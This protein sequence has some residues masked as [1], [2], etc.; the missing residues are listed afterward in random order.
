MKAF[1]FRGQAI[2][3]L[4][5]KTHPLVY[6]IWVREIFFIVLHYKYPKKLYYQKLGTDSCFAKLRAISNLFS[7][8][9]TP[10]IFIWSS[11]HSARWLSILSFRTSAC[12]CNA[13]KTFCKSIH[14]KG[15][16]KPCLHCICIVLVQYCT[17]L[18][19]FKFQIVNLITYFTSLRLRWFFFV[20]LNLFPRVC[21]RL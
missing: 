11:L 15:L 6:K 3:S 8:F 20:L 18:G 2:F 4:L 16:Y 14:R 13:D 17:L 21:D 1:E 5:E 19:G 10:C 12:D 7:F 9:Y